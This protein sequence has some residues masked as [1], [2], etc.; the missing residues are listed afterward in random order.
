MTVRFHYLEVMFPFQRRV[1]SFYLAGAADKD[2]WVTKF[3]ILYTVR[4]NYRWNTIV[5]DTG[6]IVVS[7]HF[8]SDTV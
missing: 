6:S 1:Q 7:N 5:N 4:K 8:C 2:S 3:G